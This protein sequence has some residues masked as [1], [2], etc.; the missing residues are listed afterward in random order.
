MRIQRNNGERLFNK[1]EKIYHHKTVKN[2]LKALFK[3]IIITL[4]SLTIIIVIAISTGYFLLSPKLEEAQRLC[5]EKLSQISDKSFTFLSNTQ[6]F[7]N[8]NNLIGEI[9]SG[10]FKYIEFDDIS[11][12]IINGYIAVEDRNFYQHNG[13]DYRAIGRAFGSLIE[14][15]GEVTQGGSTI[16]QQLLKNNVLNNISNKWDRKLIEF[17][18][19]PKLEEKYS[20]EK[21]IEFYCNTNFYHNNCYGIEAAAQYYFGKSAKDVELDEA[22]VL[23]GLSNNPTKYDPIKYPDNCIDK[24]NRVIDQMVQLGYVSY[25]E[26][27]KSKTKKLI[28]ALKRP[29][30]KDNLYY[31]V[32]L[33]IHN[34]TLILMDEEGF[35]FKYT[36]SSINEQ[37]DYEQK[38]KE[39][40]NNIYSSIRSGGYK[41]YT[42][43]DRDKQNKLQSILDN[44]LAIFDEKA[45]DGRYAMQASATLIDNETGAVIAVVGG[46]GNKD[47][48]N[49]AYQSFRQ[50]GSSIKPIIDYAPAFDTK[51][52]YPS[53]LIDDSKDSSDKAFPENWDGRYKGLIS[54]REATIRSTNTAAYRVLR[55][56]VGV[57]QG[58]KILEEMKFSGLD[59]WDNNNSS[60]SIGGFTKG[61]SSYEMA[62]AYYTLSNYGIYND[63]ICIRR[64]EY[65]L[66]GE[67]EEIYSYK[68]NNK[69][70]YQDYSA[71]MIIDIL[72]DVLTKS[73]GTG[74][75]AYLKG[76]DC[77][78]KTGTTNNDKDGWFCGMTPRYSMA[79]WCGYDIPKTI[80]NLGGGKY[81]MSIWRK[82]QEYLYSTLGDEQKT[83]QFKAP[84]SVIEGYVDKNGNYSTNKT[85]K[86]DWFPE[87]LIE[88]NVNYNQ[89]NLKILLENKAKE[90]LNSTPVSNVNFYNLYNEIVAL[91]SD[92]DGYFNMSDIW[93][94]INKF[95]IKNEN[96]IQYQPSSTNI[97]EDKNSTVGSNNIDDEILFDTPITKEEIPNKQNENNTESAYNQTNNGNHN[98]LQMELNEEQ[99]IQPSDNET[100]N[101]IPE[102]IKNLIESD[103]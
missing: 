67:S 75:T 76:I 20:K 68:E 1:K 26:G 63:N 78:G 94:H 51:K 91:E 66:G 69:V 103:D 80:P 70:I 5:N 21:I 59:Y 83:K 4:L 18:L 87:L 85:E 17:F 54:I 3:V 90:F 25:S 89:N 101:I 47:E 72:R 39:V 12:Y 53:S 71:F 56:I 49:R 13:I 62:K 38:Y 46:R 79:V 99:K 9:N 28:L 11:S 96:D 65:V 44:E 84:P 64:A 61:V 40:Y 15:S 16:T 37:K 48:F 32:S 24:R 19:A 93:K 60:L 30:I 31:P 88:K 58:L 33:S 29:E 41:I 92:Y 95:N 14:N 86:I 100:K 2:F 102:P 23:V 27:E 34:M 10:S 82:M 77:A 57:K 50:P 98:I 97:D 74:G 7:D 42:T 52:Y 43:I 81:S 36:F 6:I 8:D 55:D 73:Y 35:E 45:D 22:A